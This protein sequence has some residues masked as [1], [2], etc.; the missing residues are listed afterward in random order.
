MGERSRGRARPFLKQ[1]Y[2]AKEFSI[3]A[4]PYGLSEQTLAFALAGLEGAAAPLRQ[5]C[6]LR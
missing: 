2:A 5:A 4:T 6:N 1:V 3:R